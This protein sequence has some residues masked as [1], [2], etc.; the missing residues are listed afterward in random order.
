ML[1]PGT[2][3][4]A[5]GRMRDAKIAW[6]GR[7]KKRERQKKDNIF[8]AH[9]YVCCTLEKEKILL[10]TTEKLAFGGASNFVLNTFTVKY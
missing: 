9:C 4:Y 8:S 7:A 1:V 3:L 2:D 5:A 6:L 10:F